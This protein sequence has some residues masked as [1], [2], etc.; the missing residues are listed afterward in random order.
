MLTVGEFARLT[1]LSIRTLRRYHDS[2][3]LVPDRVD[4]ATGYRYYTPAQIPNAQVIHRL[5]ELDLPLAEVRR[6]LDSE[7]P[8]ERARIVAAHLRRLEDQLEQTRRAVVS[9][10]QLLAPEPVAVELRRVP[11]L[12]V[13]AIEAVV[14][15][16]DVL[17]WYSGAM[18]ELDAMALQGTPGGVYDNALFTEGRGSALV[19]LPSAVPPTGGRVLPVT[20]PAAELAVAV[21]EG[22]H[23]AIDVT[24]GRLGRWAAEHSLAIGGPVREHYL[25]GPRDTADAASWRT[26]IAWPVFTVAG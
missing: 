24:Y 21:H 12:T 5:R 25:C 18:A 16:G 11:P 26:E 9:L 23:D 3:L 8:D 22:A 17:S 4:E 19:Y 7:D 15:L 13:A 20:L 6:V 2:G 10:R 1:H 14:D